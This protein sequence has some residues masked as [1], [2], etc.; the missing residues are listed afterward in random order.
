MHAI[1]VRGVSKQF[2]RYGRRRH[3]ATLKSALLSGRPAASVR[4]EGVFDALTDVSF[5][6]TAGR[7]FGVIGRNGSGKSTLLKLLA[8]IGKPT[9]GSIHVTGRVSALIELG[10]GFHPDF[11]GRE[12]VYLNGTI[13]GL[14]QRQIEERFD[15]IVLVHGCR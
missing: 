6:V 7:S 2:R 10:A 12:N 5:D 4:P 13:H 8:G 3:F 14:T 15:D 1:E 11:T 9:T